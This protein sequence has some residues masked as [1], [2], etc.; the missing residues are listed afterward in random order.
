MAARQ[1]AADVRLVWVPSL[2]GSPPSGAWWPRSRD[3]AVEV[4]AL[5]PLVAMHLD[6]AVT[7]VSLNIDAWDANQPRRLRV[8]DRLVRLGWFRTL[9]AATVTLAR[10]SGARVTLH[11]VAP[12]LDP[13]AARELLRSLSTSSA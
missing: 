3:A 4:T 8:G 10:G 2:G 13:A 6:G 1:L 5:L 9:D 12:E 7:R 11:V